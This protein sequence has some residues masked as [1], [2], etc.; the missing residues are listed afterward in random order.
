VLPLL[1]ALTAFA[2]WLVGTAC[3]ATGV[4]QWLSL[5]SKRRLYPVMRWRRAAL[6]RRWLNARL[7]ELVD[8]LR[9]ALLDRLACPH[10]KRGET[11]GSES[12]FTWW[13]GPN[14]SRKFTLTES[15]TEWGLARAAGQ[16]IPFFPF[17]GCRKNLHFQPTLNVQIFYLHD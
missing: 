15:T 10:E 11:S 8:Q 4:D 9:H 7:S 13:F 1:S 16:R 3:E 14:L 17:T 5:R 6:V 2:M 12:T